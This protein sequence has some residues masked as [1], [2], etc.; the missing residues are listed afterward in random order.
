MEHD[1]FIG[2]LVG[3]TGDPA[4]LTVALR[5]SHSARRGEFVRIAHQG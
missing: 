4:K 5:D 1:N 2:K 3:D